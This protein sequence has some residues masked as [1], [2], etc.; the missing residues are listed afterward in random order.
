MSLVTP[1]P[2]FIKE[3]KILLGWCKALIGGFAI[4]KK[5]FWIVLWNALTE[6]KHCS[7]LDT[8]R[9]CDTRLLAGTKLLPHQNQ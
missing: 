8:S 3:A 9:P 6:L 1:S 7:A 2:I 5:C 4:P